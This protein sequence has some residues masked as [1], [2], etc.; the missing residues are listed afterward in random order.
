MWGV[1]I[2]FV[3]VGGLVKLS[4]RE[5]TDP[6]IKPAVEKLRLAKLAAMP[7]SRLTLDQ[8]ED[9]VVLSRRLGEKELARRFAMVVK[10]LKTRRGKR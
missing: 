9:G 4:F 2:A 8:A 7:P 5:A 3:L 10:V 6:V 1:L